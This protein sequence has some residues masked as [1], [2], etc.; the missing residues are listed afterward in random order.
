MTLKNPLWRFITYFSPS[1]SSQRV[2]RRNPQGRAS[3]IHNP[4]TSLLDEIGHVVSRSA[5]SEKSK[6]S[7]ADGLGA[8]HTGWPEVNC[9]DP[10]QLHSYLVLF[11][12]STKSLHKLLFNQLI[13]RNTDSLKQQGTSWQSLILKYIEHFTNQ[14]QN[15]LLWKPNSSWAAV[16]LVVG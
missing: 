9:F 3:W 15:P 6:I 12:P 16:S 11:L 7:T 10:N 5:W 1:T 4:S 8:R 2:E 13:H 14:I